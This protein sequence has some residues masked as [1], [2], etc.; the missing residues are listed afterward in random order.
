MRLAPPTRLTVAIS[1]IPARP[2][3]PIG[4]E[5]SPSVTCQSSTRSFGRKGLG[6]ERVTRLPLPWVSGRQTLMVVAPVIFTGP[7]APVPVSGGGRGVQ[8]GVG[9]GEGG[10]GDG[11]PG[12]DPASSK[13]AQ[14]A[15]RTRAGRSHAERITAF[16]RGGCARRRAARWPA[17]T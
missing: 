9:E 4:P 10:G 13:V 8:G 17:S 11:V 7:S 12:E 1:Q 16:Y 6:S 15:T 5:V 14:P 2:G 3:S